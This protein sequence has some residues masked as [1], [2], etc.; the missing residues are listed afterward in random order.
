[1]L[2]TDAQCLPSSELGQV[3]DNSFEPIV[4]I[5]TAAG[6]KQRLNGN[7]AND[8]KYIEFFATEVSSAFSCTCNG[9]WTVI[10]KA[11]AKLGI[12]TWD[13]GGLK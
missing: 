2:W 6:N 9:I 5:Q 8:Y 4:Q 7:K 10:F 12:G 13:Q 11:A 1:M 3:K